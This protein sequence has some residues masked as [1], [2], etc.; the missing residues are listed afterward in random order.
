MHRLRTPDW[1]AGI[2]GFVLLLSLFS[3]WYTVVDGTID[4]WSA[5]AFIDVWLLLT[6]LM[7]IGVT[8]STATR[9][10]PAVPL[11]FEVLTVWMAFVAAI[12][13]VFRLISVADDEVVT[14]RSWGLF[15]AAAAV[16]AIFAACWWA[17]RR[18]DQPGLRPPPEVRVMPVPL[19]RDP[20]TPPT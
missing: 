14:G 4:A 10:A 3:P 18:Q 13:M 20:T 6:A 7:A 19:E 9:D 15:L 11:V 16:V 12:M 2:A 8:I 1:L 17:M 5:L